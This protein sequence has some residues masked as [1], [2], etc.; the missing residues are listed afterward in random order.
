MGPPPGEDL[1]R[2]GGDGHFQGVVLGRPGDVEAAVLR[3]LHHLQ[4]VARHLAHVEAVVHALQIDG[5]LEFH[6]VPPFESSFAGENGTARDEIRGR[7]ATGG[8]TPTPTP[9]HKGEGD[10]K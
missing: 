4:R 10:S 2:V 9:P 5:E 8:A 1:E 7:S 6:A 3:H